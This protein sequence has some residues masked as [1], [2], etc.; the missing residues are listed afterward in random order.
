[1][2]ELLDTSPEAQ[3]VLIRL[4][5]EPPPQRKLELAAEMFETVKLLA[6]SGLRTRYPDAGEE[7]LRR[8]L[9]D[10]LLGEELAR[11]AYGPRW[12]EDVEG[13]AREPGS[14]QGK[15]IV[16]EDFNAPL[17]DDILRDFGL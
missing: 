10:I 5:R 4:M 14:A 7:E 3:V 13:E 8:R 2:P 11:K 1:M 12:W 17:P 15:L 6:L 16:L 9:A